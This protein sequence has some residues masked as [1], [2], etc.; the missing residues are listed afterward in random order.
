MT[1][2]VPLTPTAATPARTGFVAEART[3]LSQDFDTF[4]SLLTTQLQNQDPLEPTDP[5][6][7]VAQLTQFTELE[8]TMA[9]TETLTEVAALLKGQNALSDLSLLGRQVEAVSGEVALKDGAASFDVRTDRPVTKGAVRIFDENDRLV[10]T[11]DVRDV[12]GRATVEWNGM[13]E[14]GGQAADGSYRAEIVSLD[15]AEPVLAGQV[16][17]TGTVSQVAFTGSGSAISLDNGLVIGSE[18]IVAVR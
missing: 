6:E 8:Q 15:G 10:A 3:T 4:I 9:Q 17:I 16:L 11:V 14:S 18:G 13:R 12:A 7:F 5:S 1:D 2:I